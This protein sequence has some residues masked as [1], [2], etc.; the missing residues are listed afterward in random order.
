LSRARKIV[1][2]E[3]R[4]IDA[5]C[6]RF[7][8]GS[9]LSRLNRSG[10]MWTTVS[11]LLGEAL[12]AALVAAERTDGAVDPTVGRA[13]EVLGY[14][15]DYDEVAA[16]DPALPLGGAPEPAGGW[17]RV[18][19]HPSGR[20]ARVPEGLHLDLGATAKALCVDRAAER[21]A[22]ALEAGV[23]VAIGGDVGVAGPAPVGGWRLAVV[24]DVRSPV[25][26]DD[27]VV[28]VRAGGV[29]SSGTTARTWT[30][31]GLPLHH[32]IDPATGWPAPSTWR[33]V[34]VAAP[35]CVV[36]NTAATA[37]VVWGGE[38]LFRLPQLGLSARLV[39]S[40]GAVLE[41]GAW[42]RSGEPVLRGPGDRGSCAAR[43]SA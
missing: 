31:A 18:S 15:R 3:I 39:R 37:A 32:V 20:A 21:A 40:D 12:E 4:A 17:W 13:L 9:E 26:G 10:G 38:A 22:G 23:L 8:A 34:T 25:P 19:L 35:S 41:V 30:R 29:A 33:M 2:D 14:D 16:G 11:S 24:E 1:A 5:A 28:A 27:C 43:A 6:N 7:S 42:P 36:A